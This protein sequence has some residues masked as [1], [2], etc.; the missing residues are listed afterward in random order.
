M[1]I[2]RVNILRELFTGREKLIEL[3]KKLQEEKSEN[4]QMEIER[5]RQLRFV[6]N[7]LKG[8]KND[9][10]Y[11]KV[12]MTPIVE[13][14][15]DKCPSELNVC[16][17]IDYSNK[18]H[19]RM[20]LLLNPSERVNTDFNIIAYDIQ[21]A[22]DRLYKK[23]NLTDDDIEFIEIYRS[24]SGNMTSISKELN[25]HKTQVYRDLEKILKKIIKEIN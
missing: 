14:D 13:I 2:E 25:R 12:T 22:I 21:K 4:Q 1:E 20:A 23:K 18:E 24:L 17:S 6:I 8:I 9:L 19:M 5:R 11:C 7:A 15:A 16:D 3:K 10:I